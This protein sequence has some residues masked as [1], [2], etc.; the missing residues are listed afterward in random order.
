MMG[1][2]MNQIGQNQIENE[3]EKIIF[4]SSLNSK[5]YFVFSLDNLKIYYKE[6]NIT[7]N[8]IPNFNIIYNNKYQSLLGTENVKYGDVNQLTDKYEL[9][10][11][12]EFNIKI[13]ELYEIKI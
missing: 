9:T 2:Q 1:N 3:N 7:G 6:D 10:G 12:K 8:N 4:S 5:N 11:K 13:L